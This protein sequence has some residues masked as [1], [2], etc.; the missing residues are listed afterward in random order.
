MKNKKRKKIINEVKI[1]DIGKMPSKNFKLK[2]CKTD[3]QQL[4]RIE[5]KLNK[6]LK[7]EK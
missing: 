6:L 7:D 3:K 1:A 5:K 4:N 2:V